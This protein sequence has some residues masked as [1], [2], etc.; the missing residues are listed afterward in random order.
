MKEK[1]E[2][3]EV[4]RRPAFEMLVRDVKMHQ[5]W[6]IESDFWAWVQRVQE[7]NQG[8]RDYLR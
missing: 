4:L 6:Q 2:R 5:L 3:I 7:M 1:S 8:I